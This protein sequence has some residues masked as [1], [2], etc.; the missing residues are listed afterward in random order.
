MEKEPKMGGKP[1]P[2]EEKAKSL[3]PK[4]VKR[5]PKTPTQQAN[6]ALL[7]LEVGRR[8]ANNHPQWQVPF[9]DAVLMQREGQ[10]LKDMLQRVDSN[11]T[12]KKRNTLDL[13]A[14][15]KRINAAITKLKGYIRTEYD[16]TKGWDEYFKE[17]GLTP[18]KSGTYMLIADNALRQVA[19][20]KLIAKLQEANNPFANRTL[21]LLQWQDLQ[22]QHARLW[23]TSNDLRADRSL[24][25]PQISEQ[26]DK[27]QVLFDKMLK[28]IDLS[29][30]KEQAV[31]LKRSLGFLKESF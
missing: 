30:N 2:K 12:S 13:E 22:Q 17:Y 5:S 29:L 14:S 15:N 24:L 3:T 27:L 20:Q 26:Y 23:E 8:W 10:I 28:Y 4:K 16:S 21:G 7:S 11:E 25:T 31:G 19:L 6:A 9:A 18:N 1:T